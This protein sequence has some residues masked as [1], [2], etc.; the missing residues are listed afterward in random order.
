MFSD[1][2]FLFT[3][4]Q[5]I[6]HTTVSSLPGALLPGCTTQ[7]KQLGISRDP[8]HVFLVCFWFSTLCGPCRM[9]PWPSTAWSHPHPSFHYHLRS[10]MFYLVADSV[11]CSSLYVSVSLLYTL[12]PWNGTGEPCTWSLA[13]L[14]PNLQC[15]RE[16]WLISQPVPSRIFRTFSQ[17]CLWQIN[18]LPVWNQSPAFLGTCQTIPLLGRPHHCPQSPWL[19]AS[20]ETLLSS[21]RNSTRR[22]FLPTSCLS[23]ASPAFCCPLDKSKC[24]TRAP[25]WSVYTAHILRTVTL[26]NTH[27]KRDSI[28]IQE[29]LTS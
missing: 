9:W 2:F 26:T 8:L 19:T 3:A 17:L 13:F 22:A 12:H 18:V 23:E 21:Q 5:S 15:P 14:S 6:T 20:C 16:R 24:L 29:V 4:H 10:S 11:F 1:C 7:R 27:V 28:L 25:E